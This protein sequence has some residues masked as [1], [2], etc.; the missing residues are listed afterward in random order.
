MTC[1]RPTHPSQGLTRTVS[2]T[3]SELWNAWRV[4]SEIR[5]L[6]EGWLTK[7]QGWTEDDVNLYSIKIEIAWLSATQLVIHS[8]CT[9]V[10]HQTN[11]H[12]VVIEK[13]EAK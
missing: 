6:A 3:A 12:G 11:Y 5:E 2:M 13:R 1:E 10:R 7:R 9:V 8:D 4:S